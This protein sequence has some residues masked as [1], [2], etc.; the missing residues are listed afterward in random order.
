M[1]KTRDK[2]MMSSLNTDA[3]NND[4]AGLL[5]DEFMSEDDE[6]R[7]SSREVPVYDLRGPKK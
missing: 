3:V 6:K 1:R 5:I 7:L 4:F 2:P